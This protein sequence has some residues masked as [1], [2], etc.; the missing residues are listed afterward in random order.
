[1]AATI[2]DSVDCGAM[3]VPRANALLGA[4]GLRFRALEWSGSR[5]GCCCFVH[6]TSFCADGWQPVIARST[7][8]ARQCARCVAIDQRGHGGSDAPREPAAYSWTR[9]AEDVGEIAAAVAPD[10]PLVGV[11]HSSGATAL[12]AAAARH[13]ERF[14]ALVAVEP[15]LFEGPAGPGGGSF[16]G[17][18]HLA[19]A[20]RRRRDRF[21]SSAEARGRLRAKAP[22]AAF[23]DAAFEAALRGMLEPNGEGVSLRCP[24]EREAWCYEGAAALDLWP[25]AAKIRAPLLLVLG[26]HSAV[27][28]GLRDRLIDALA[29]VRIA[30]IPGGTRLH[31]AGRTHRGG[32]RDRAFP[33]R[34]RMSARWFV[35]LGAAVWR[36]G[37]PS[38]ALRR[39]VGA[40]IEAARDFPNAHFLPT[41]GVGRHAPSEA[42]V[43]QRLLRDAGIA[44]GRIV[45]EETG[46]DT[47]S[48]VVACVRILEAAGGCDSVTVCTDS[49][50]VA[51]VR[52]VFR[53]LGVRTAAAPAHGAA[54]A[55]GLRRYAWALTREALGVPWDVA[56][57][58]ARRGIAR[59][60]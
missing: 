37:E 22:F 46:T 27:A 6:A 3:P 1:M 35:I 26:E 53:V 2:T 39:R 60:R 51:R 58:I 31:R 40:A 11:G 44:A 16:A 48:S 29:S 28:P 54:G 38:P 4:N 14:A 59:G 57:A 56:L 7:R 50:H 8:R 10:A 17:S 52:A 43:M 18:R 42:V 47:L 5:A 30:T 19:N 20:A 9:L 25:L 12:L 36:G 23:A 55:L 33:R 34:R 13:P 49:Y 32:R 21:A 45:L 15:V 24:G 41:G